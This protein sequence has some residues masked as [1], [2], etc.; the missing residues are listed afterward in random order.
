MKLIPYINLAG[1]AEEAMNFYKDVFGGKIEIN[2][3]NEM[4]P[5]PKMPVSEA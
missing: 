3:W 1:N 5:N 2:R 4:P